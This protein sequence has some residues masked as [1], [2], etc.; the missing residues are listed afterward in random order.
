M[1]EAVGDEKF[2]VR[3][4][5]LYHL[6]L[7]ESG[8]GGQLGITKVRQTF[9]TP[10][11][12]AIV[13]K[14]WSGA[15]NAP[16]NRGFDEGVWSHHDLVEWVAYPTFNREG[17]YIAFRG[18]LLAGAV[19]NHGVGSDGASGFQNF[20]FIWADGEE[21]GIA[22]GILPSLPSGRTW[23]LSNSDSLVASTYTILDQTTEEFIINFPFASHMVGE[24]SD[25][26]VSVHG[27]QDA[28]RT[29]TIGTDIDL[30][31]YARIR[32]P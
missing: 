13:E 3:L 31:G 6:S 29:P 28:T 4:R 22:G 2:G 16:E 10:D 14:H 23:D 5:E 32:V 20:T 19:L 27:F 1:L 21:H 24:P 17:N 30:L 12:A 11:E 15:M 8:S 7:G 25:Y 18:R 9:S 26:V